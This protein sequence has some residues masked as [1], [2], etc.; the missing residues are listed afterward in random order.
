MSKDN[1][2]KRIITFIVLTFLISAPLYYFIVQGGGLESSSAQ[3]LVFP[4]MWTPGIAGIITTLIYQK[5]LRGMGWGLGKGKYYLVAF[6]VPILY[7]G[8]AY[9]AVWLLGLGKLEFSL[10]GVGGLVSSLSLGVLTALLTAMGEEIGWRGVMVPQLFRN[11]TFIHTAV[12]TGV[13][14]GI[15]HIPLI[16]SG[17]YSSGAPTWF[18]VT[19]FMVVVIGMS[20]AFAWVRLSSGSFWPAALMHAVHNSFI[21]GFLD[22][23]TVNTGNTEYFSTEFGLALAIM[24]I[25]VAI[26]FSRIGVPATKES[27]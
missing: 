27:S 21:Q 23:V 4:L 11:N 10:S 3:A 25:I 7:A 20:F 5:N 16:I 2:N 18:A 15:W 8:V 9:G 19:A 12:I 26:I 6:L 13:V 14:W 17:G 1:A 24:G 22:K